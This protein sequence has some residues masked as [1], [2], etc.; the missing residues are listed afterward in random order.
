[1]GGHNLLIGGSGIATLQGGT[2]TNILVGGATSYDDPSTISQ[3]ALEQLLVNWNANAGTK[4]KLHQVSAAP[5]PSLSLNTVSYD[6]QRDLLLGNSRSW[7]IGRSS[8]T[9]GS[10]VFY[11][12]KKIIQ[13][14]ATPS[15][16]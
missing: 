11:N 7:F 13:N 14:A 10:D 16:Q 9:G 5:G 1:M 6:N 3:T 12:G 4:T 15:G 8:A 2:G